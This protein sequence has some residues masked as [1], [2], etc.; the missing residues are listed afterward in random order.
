VRGRTLHDE[1]EKC[2]LERLK[3]K[4]AEADNL[5]EHSSR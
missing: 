4:C 2:F 1:L 3:A 5:K